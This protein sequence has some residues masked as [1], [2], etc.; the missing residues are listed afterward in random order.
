MR[1]GPRLCPCG[2]RRR[3]N[4]VHS[5]RLRFSEAELCR[6]SLTLTPPAVR[7]HS[8]VLLYGDGPF[9]EDALGFQGPSAGNT[10]LYCSTSW[11]SGTWGA[12]SCTATVSGPSVREGRGL[13]AAWVPLSKSAF[14]GWRHG[15]VPSV[16]GPPGPAPKPASLTARV[17]AGG[18][19]EGLKKHLQNR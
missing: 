4:N 12:Q 7:L 3:A 15:Q 19:G 17:S 6:E 11:G 14:R 8:H 1:S 9:K 16:L 10:G 13:G 18:S 2:E 5:H